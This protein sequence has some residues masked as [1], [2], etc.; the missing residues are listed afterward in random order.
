MLDVVAGI[1]IGISNNGWIAVIIASI[2]WGYVVF[3]YEYIV[4]PKYNIFKKEVAYKYSD[5]KHTLLKFMFIEWLAS[6][7][8]ALPFS[9]GTYAIKIFLL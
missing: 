3:A 2:V 7:C 1:I 9:L 8:T 5:A 4:T 6:A